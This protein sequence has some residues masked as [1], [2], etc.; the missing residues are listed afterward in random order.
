M[1]WCGWLCVCVCI[2]VFVCVSVCW[3]VYLC[4]YLCVCVFVC[5]CLCVYVC[6]CICVCVC[7]CVYLCVC[8]CCVYVWGGIPSLNRAE[9]MYRTQ[10]HAGSFQ[11]L[12]G[13]MLC[14]LF[15]VQ[16]FFRRAHVLF[17]DNIIFFSDRKEHTVSKFLNN[18]DFQREAGFT[19]AY[20]YAGKI[21]KVHHTEKLEYLS[22]LC[23]GLLL[24][25][26]GEK[27][28]GLLG[29]TF[30]MLQHLESC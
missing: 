12:V 7:V 28:T 30:L 3:C 4:V 13:F 1:Q 16:I 18:G 6:V 10:H 5:V 19:R 14:T 8:V 29:G 9:I 2:C 26:S 17:L 21:H 27:R 15:I 24:R 22:A 23:R 20:A 11:V 25:S